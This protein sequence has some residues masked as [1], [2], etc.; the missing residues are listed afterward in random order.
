MQWGEAQTKHWPRSEQLTKAAIKTSIKVKRAAEIKNMEAVGSN[1]IVVF[2]SQTDFHQM[3][4][5]VGIIL[6]NN[7]VCTLPF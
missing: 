4:L 1:H 7:E 5:K 2:I 3:I 6:G